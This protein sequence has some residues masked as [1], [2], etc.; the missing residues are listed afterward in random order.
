M[1]IVLERGRILEKGRHDDLMTIPDGVYRKLY[2]ERQ[3]V[4]GRRR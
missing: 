2:E 4:E 1:I 3:R